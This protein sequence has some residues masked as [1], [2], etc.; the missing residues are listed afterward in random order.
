MAGRTMRYLGVGA[1]LGGALV[2]GAAMAVV[3]VGA[4]SKAQVYRPIQFAVLLELDFGSIIAGSSGGT[5]ILDP[6]S[7]SR[8][9]GTMICTGSFSWSRLA[10]SG[11]DATVAISY[12]PIFY[13]TGPG[14][15]IG[16]ELTY[17]GGSGSQIEMTGGSAEIQFGAILHV[18]PDQV[19]GAY[20]GE[21]AVD[22][23]YQ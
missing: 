5:V 10:I 21:F 9:C 1:A 8:D 11:S 22:V 7:S 12:A 3:P 17:A 15:P 19:P 2:P 23:N 4:D 13:L 6:T 20:S 14:A 16:A 18:N